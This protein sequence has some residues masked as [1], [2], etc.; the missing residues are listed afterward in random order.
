ME[1]IRLLFHTFVKVERLKHQTDFTVCICMVN[2]IELLST[3]L[4]KFVASDNINHIS[5]M[6]GLKFNFALFQL[7]WYLRLISDA[8]LRT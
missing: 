8:K 5:H 6:I 3:V 4:N 7:L 1:Q 2:Y